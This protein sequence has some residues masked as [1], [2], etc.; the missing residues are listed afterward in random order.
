MQND[1]LEQELVRLRELYKISNIKIQTRIM[2][3][4]S[5]IKKAMALSL[6]KTLE[7]NVKETLL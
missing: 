2:K 3:R 5:L 1:L 7:Q 6:V 4:A